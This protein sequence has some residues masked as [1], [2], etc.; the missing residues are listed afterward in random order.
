MNVQSKRKIFP[1]DERGCDETDWYRSYSTFNFGKYFNEHKHPFDDLYVLND[2]TLAGGMHFNINI[3]EN[4]VM[5]LLPVAGAVTYKDTYGNE[6]IINT[7]QL[8][9]SYL[10][11]GAAI[12]ISNAY[13]YE[14]IN[15]LQPRIKT[16]TSKTNIQPEIFS[17]DLDKNKN[18]LIRLTSASTLNTNNAIQFTLTSIGKFTGREEAV[19]RMKNK[20]SNLFVF[21]IEGVFE[22]QGH[23]L[24]ARDGLGLWDVSEDKELEALSNDAIVLMIELSKE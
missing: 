21:V 5:L 17:F 20:E 4:S 11:K 24:H 1:A 22:V 14:L 9:V 3:E 16:D 15:F 8:Q 2:D 7:G 19:Y 10:H 23:L 18:K 12:E 6:S 13:K